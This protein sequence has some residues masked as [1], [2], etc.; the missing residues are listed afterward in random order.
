MP[1][2]DDVD[3]ILLDAIADQIGSDQGQLTETA[4]DRAST[5]RESAQ[6][7]TGIDKPGGEALRRR[8]IELADIDADG[9]DV[10][11]RLARPDYSRHE[12][13]NG[14][15]SGVPHF[16]SHSATLS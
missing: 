15:S 2:A 6:P 13:G 4:A 5:A 10:G 9:L 12:S 8:R 16:S 3:G 11:Q 14:F 1:D 7:V